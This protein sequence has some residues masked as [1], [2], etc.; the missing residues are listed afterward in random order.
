MI[1]NLRKLFLG[2]FN[3]L[4][5]FI[6]LHPLFSANSNAHEPLGHR[7]VNSKTTVKITLIGCKFQSG[8]HR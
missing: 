1:K 4:Y 6:Y 8:E 3:V 5:V 2:I 7:Y